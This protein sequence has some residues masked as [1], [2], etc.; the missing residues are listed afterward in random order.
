MRLTPDTHIFWEYGFFKLNATLVFTIVVDALLIVAAYLATR[1]VKRG[2]EMTRWQSFLELVVGT[3][4]QQ[5]RDVAG[6]RGDRYL[7]FVGT[8][9]LYIAIANLLTIVPYYEPPTASLSTTSAL[10]LCVFVAVPFYGIVDRGLVGYLK[11]YLEPSPF[12]L[13]FNLISDVTRTV[14]LSIRLFGN[15]MS[16]SLIVAL[17][18]ALAPFF[19]PVLVNLLGLITGLIQAYIF[20]ILATVFIAS[21]ERA[22]QRNAPELTPDIRPDRGAGAPP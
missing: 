21:G 20:A 10:A 18:L 15:I 2:L 6:P 9:F 3:I 7:P 11:R 14:A 19:F 12:M 8:L 5:L 13:P 17:F 22:Q 4:R 16:G 1:D